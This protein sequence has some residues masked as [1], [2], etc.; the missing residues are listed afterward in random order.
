MASRSLPV[1]VPMYNVPMYEVPVYKEE[2]FIHKLLSWVIAAPRPD[3]LDCEIVV[4]DEC[5]S[6]GSAEI[7]ENFTAASPAAKN[8]CTDRGHSILEA[9]WFAPE[10][11]R[12]LA[13][14]ISSFVGHKV[15]RSEPAWGI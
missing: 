10:F 12:W 11:N 6:D 1:V 4:V 2:E 15:P 5:S 13:D 14:T 3:C 8:I 9:L 7:V